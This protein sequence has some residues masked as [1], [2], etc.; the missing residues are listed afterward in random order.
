MRLLKSHFNHITPRDNIMD[1]NIGLILNETQI[2]VKSLDTET[3]SVGS[4][5]IS[6]S[7]LAKQELNLLFFE[8][9]EKLENVAQE[10]KEQEAHYPIVDI[11]SV[12]MP[13]SSFDSK[14]FE[15]L[16][17]AFDKINYRWI[18]S[19]N[20]Q[21]IESMCG[22][23]KQLKEN[24]IKDRNQ[25]FKDLWQV[26]KTNLASIE[27]NIIFHDLKEP[28][29]AAK[30]KGEKP[31]LSYSFIKG[32]KIGEIQ[33]GGEAEKTLLKDYEKD[34]N[35][36]F[37]ITEYDATKGQLV[38]CSNLERSPILILATVAELNQLQRSV[39]SGLMNGLQI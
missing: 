33:E 36:N 7:D 23:V 17:M 31:T 6:F 22:Q 13:A 8:Q 2:L 27:L 4:K 26:F 34:F 18:L 20:I 15:E 9:I 35:E 19:N 5:N 10:L 25:F 38:I 30:E 16:K 37:K 3:Q 28:T 12:E 21:M 32:K 24:W 39:L 29:A 11:S 1:I 14:S